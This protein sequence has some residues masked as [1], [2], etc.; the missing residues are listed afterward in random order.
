MNELIIPES[1]ASITI[2]KWRD[3][4]KLLEGFKV[5]AFNPNHTP[6]GDWD[7]SPAREIIDVRTFVL[8]GKRSE[9]SNGVLVWIHSPTHH[10]HAHGRAGGCG[11]H[12]PSA[13]FSSALLAMGIT[14]GEHECHGRGDSAM[15][16][17]ALAIAQKL[18]YEQ[19]YL[20]I[21]KFFR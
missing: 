11:Y 21:A 3:T 18:G 16:D 19:K 7:Y 12:R 10:G 15:Y 4:A 1:L 13:A 20:H 6:A 8:G 17:T 5:I 14:L 9:G 2:P